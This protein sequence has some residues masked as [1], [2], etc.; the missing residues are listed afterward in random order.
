MGPLKV[1]K[2]AIKMVSQNTMVRP[3]WTLDGT[4]CWS[5]EMQLFRN[6]TCALAK[7]TFICLKQHLYIFYSI[8]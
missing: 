3:R 1:S 5:S 7:R 6:A 4:Q 8:S 2:L